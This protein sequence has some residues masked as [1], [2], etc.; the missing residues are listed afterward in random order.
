M[1]K[2]LLGN[3]GMKVSVIGFGGIPIQRVNQ[4]EATK[5]IL[6]CKNKGINF[7]DTARGYTISEGYIGN[8]LKVVGR[9]NFYIATKAMSYTY[10]SM[11]QSI[12][13]SLKTMNIDYID[14]YQ[15]HNVSKKE[16]LDSILSENGAL[17]ALIE[18]KEEGLIKH[19][20]IT[21]HIREILL[22]AIE[23]DEFETIQF[24]F[25]PVESQGEELFIK[26]LNKGMGTIAMKPIAG[27]AFGKPDLSLK[28]IINSDLITVAIPGMDSVEQVSK[29]ASIG[30]KISPLTEEEKKEIKKEIEDLGN[31]FC[32][33]C[34]YCKPC[35]EGIDIPNVFIFEGYVT[36]YNLEEY[37]KSRYETLPVKA[38][39][40]VRCRKCEKKCPY[41][42]PIVEKL[43]H[44]VK[45][46]ENL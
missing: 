15:V 6:E 45:T 18:A 30:E 8:A 31:E 13:E 23:N 26:A 36:R 20:G 19:I 35:P 5:I 37:G 7:I 28:Y 39:A 22:E 33:R 1:E 38:D 11:K 32:R 27:G 29:N 2:K 46:F 10:E 4:D 41:N 16:Q 42:L 25:N 40:C 34:G 21:G 44:A 3:T 43:K 14:L 17:K 9:E 24:P 12:E